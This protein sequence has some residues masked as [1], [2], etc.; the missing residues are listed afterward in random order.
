MPISLVAPSKG[1][2]S[3]PSKQFASKIGFPLPATDRAYKAQA[4]NLSTI[5][6][7]A[8]DIPYYVASGFADFGITGRDIVLESGQQV[9]EIAELPFG[10]C[11]V[12]LAS[13]SRISSISDLEG[14]R[15]A[16]EFPVIAKSYLDSRGIV[17]EIIRLDGATELA[18]ATGLADAIIDISSSGK[19]LAENGLRIKDFVMA[20]KAVLIASKGSLSKADSILEMIENMGAVRG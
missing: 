17:A 19:T 16:T 3:V 10:D 13:D 2:L 6:A 12:V 9:F 1:R 15:I 8:R 18:I 20:S 7:R 14:G 5:F 11:G 4:D